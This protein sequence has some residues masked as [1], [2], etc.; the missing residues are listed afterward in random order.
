MVEVVTAG[1]SYQSR[2]ARPTFLGSLRAGRGRRARPP[3]LRCEVLPSARVTEVRVEVSAAGTTLEADRWPLGEL[4]YSAQKG[5]W[6]LP[7]PSAQLELDGL[8]VTAPARLTGGEVLATCHGV[9]LRLLV[10]GRPSPATTLSDAEGFAWAVRTGL[11]EVAERPGLRRA[12]LRWGGSHADTLAAFG[13]TALARSLTS[14]DLVVCRGPTLPAVDAGTV[15][16][17]AKELGDLRPRTCFVLPSPLALPDDLAVRVAEPVEIRF[18]GAP[19]PLGAPAWLAGSP[20]RLRLEKT[21]SPAPFLFSLGRSAFLSC[22]EGWGGLESLGR[23]GFDACLAGGRRLQVPLLPGDEWI[24]QSRGRTHRLTAHPAGTPAA[25]P[26]RRGARP[27]PFVFDGEELRHLTF[28]LAEGDLQ[29]AQGATGL[30][31]GPWPWSF[32][33]AGPG[34][35][36]WFRRERTFTLYDVIFDEQRRP[37]LVLPSPSGFLRGRTRLPERPLTREALEV[38]LDLLLERNDGAALAWRRLLDAG[39]GERPRW[40]S[41]LVLDYSLRETLLGWLEVERE[42][43]ARF[44]P[45]VRAA[46]EDHARALLRAL[47]TEPMF[48]HVREVDVDLPASEW[49]SPLLDAPPPPGARVIWRRDGKITERP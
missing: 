45:V 17:L 20:E 19:V 49:G 10:E 9:A 38:F 28:H 30:F 36:K 31:H 32:C 5:W 15:L 6:L 44:E 41:S 33:V 48:Q 46:R 42:S 12:I 13:R 8:A 40:F 4:R 11:L 3:R 34:T 26:H 16:A 21:Y 39:P 22:E 18:D 37:A 24:L 1:Q 27:P 29:F 2:E 43:L 47:R 23:S 7:R 35:L 14:L 25:R